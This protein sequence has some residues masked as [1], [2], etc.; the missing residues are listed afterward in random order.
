MAMGDGHSHCRNRHDEFLYGVGGSISQFTCSSTNSNCRRIQQYIGDSWKLTRSKYDASSLVIRF[1]AYCD[2]FWDTAN[3][4]ENYELCRRW[5]VCD[6]DEWRCDT[7]QCIPSDWRGDQEWDCC[8]ASD[9]KQYF[10]NR[11][12]T[13]EG[14]QLNAVSAI[15]R[16]SV[17]NE[18]HPFTCLSHASGGYESICLDFGR[19]GDGIIDCAGALDEQNRLE[20]CS[21]TGRQGYSFRCPSTPSVCIPF[22][23]HCTCHRCRNRS[24]DAFWCGQIEQQDTCSLHRNFYCFNGTLLEGSR[25]NRVFDCLSGEDEYMC[26]YPTFGDNIPTFHRLSKLLQVRGKQYHLPRSVGSSALLQTTQSMQPHIRSSSNTNCDHQ[27]KHVS[28]WCNR[29]IAIYLNNCTIICLCPP[30]YYGDKCQ[31]H[32]DRILISFRVDL[33]ASSYTR[34]TDFNISLRF[35]FKLRRH[36]ETLMIDNFYIRPRYAWQRMN[37]QTFTFVHSRASHHLQQRISRFSNRTDRLKYKP[38]NVRLEMH[39]VMPYLRPTLPF[40]VWQYPIDHDFLPVTRFFKAIR[41]SSVIDKRGACQATSCRMGQH[42]YPLQNDLAKHVCLSDDEL[43]RNHCRRAGEDVD[44]CASDAGCRWQNRSIPFCMCASHKYGERCEIEHDQCRSISCLNNGTCHRGVRLDEAF[45]QCTDE[46]RG[47][48]CEHRR[49]Y[50]NLSI[51]MH[52]T[53]QFAVVQYFHIDRVEHSLV[54]ERQSLYSSASFPSFV[55]HR[56]QSETAAEVV[57]MKVYWGDV[58]MRYDLHSLS[59]QINRSIVV[60]SVNVSD[61]TRCP[62]IQGR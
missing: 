31:Y 59:V 22:W 21:D 25:C 27:M 60:Q 20:H 54:L 23:R 57:L 14:R 39:E 43:V 56:S 26:D 38:Y 50:V 15:T 47:D 4:D 48:R 36:N 10:M 42:C 28:F 1:S 62:H 35:L 29:G 49:P 9:E 53:Y 19:V 55:V 8:D 3:G 18:T 24:D 16:L 46:Y 34:H 17:C 58:T 5:W 37:K 12:T 44:F 52:E 61:R 32:A 13:L 51:T 6:D 2:T 45:C 33:T 30:Q 40:A 7:G 41:V 11:S